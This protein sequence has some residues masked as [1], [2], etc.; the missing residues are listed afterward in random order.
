MAWGLINQ[1]VRFSWKTGLLL[2]M[3]LLPHPGEK[4]AVLDQ[5]AILWTS[6]A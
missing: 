2:Q 3:M 5:S 4:P 6:G 1:G